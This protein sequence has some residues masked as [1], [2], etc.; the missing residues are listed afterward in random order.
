MMHSL[1]RKNNSVELRL[2]SQF[3]LRLVRGEQGEWLDS[4]ADFRFTPLQ[5]I[6]ESTH[7]RAGGCADHHINCVNLHGWRL[8]STRVCTL[9]SGI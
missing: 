9:R 7:W 1:R 2:V 6:H 5:M 4:Q 3:E 8:R